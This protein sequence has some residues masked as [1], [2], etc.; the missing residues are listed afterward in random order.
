V[1]A[2]VKGAIYLRGDEGTI[3]WLA[4]P[5]SF[6]H[7]RCLLVANG[8]PAPEPGTPFQMQKDQLKFQNGQILDFSHAVCWKPPI[9]RPRTDEGIGLRAHRLVRDLSRVDHRPGFSALLPALVSEEIPANTEKVL[10]R[11]LPLLLGVRAAMLDH[12]LGQAMTVGSELIGLGEGLTPSGDDF[13]G[14]VCFFL[15]HL[16]RSAVAS[17]RFD[18]AE[19]NTLRNH[20]KETTNEISYIL[21]KDLLQ[22]KGIEP[23]YPIL[24]AL[25]YGDEKDALKN[26]IRR[27][28]AI[29][30]STGWDLL[31]GVLT[32]ALWTKELDPG[33][34]EA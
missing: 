7:D 30:S 34:S 26:A 12:D 27:L 18:F 8:L 17:A 11:A 25:F 22:G 1:L 5:G 21:L 28:T 16:K 20:A 24:S 10:T 4:G 6:M 2:V 14:G 15:Y 9:F 13:M 33:P 29:G 3:L 32:G 23:L 19:L 31:T